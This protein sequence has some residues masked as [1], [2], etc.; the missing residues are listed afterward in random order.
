MLEIKEEKIALDVLWGEKKPSKYVGKD[1][2]FSTQSCP[3]MSMFY[4]LK[5]FFSF[6]NHRN[7][8]D[9][10]KCV[11][12]KSLEIDNKTDVGALKLEVVL[13]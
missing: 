9:R 11:I 1:S 10:V 13:L 8:S 3:K 5:V 6:I 2:G 4:S 12:L 7:F